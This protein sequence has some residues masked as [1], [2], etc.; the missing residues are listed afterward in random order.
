MIFGMATGIALRQETI[1]GVEAILRLLNTLNEG[2]PNYAPYE[3][4]P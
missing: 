2:N 1:F 3:V 4:K